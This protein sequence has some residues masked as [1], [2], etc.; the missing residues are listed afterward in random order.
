MKAIL[1][2]ICQLPIGT[3]LPT[4]LG[5]FLGFFLGSLRAGFSEKRLFLSMVNFAFV[6][7]NNNISYI[8]AHSDIIRKGEH[9]A[10]APTPAGFIKG[11]LLP[12]P[13]SLSTLTSTA[14]LARFA[15]SIIWSIVI[16]R[17][18]NARLVHA[19]LANSNYLNFNDL[20]VSFAN[21]KNMYCDL[22]WSLYCLAR[23]RNIKYSM[24]HYQALIGALNIRKP[25]TIHLENLVF[26][27]KD[28]E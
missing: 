7:L 12:F 2:W 6:D 23:N 19:Q 18:S 26:Q 15:N 27:Y 1:N 11:N 13:N 28:K 24:A 17:I 4:L 25:E 21:L 5:T 8:E 16:N 9:L 20:M 14:T 3:F 22:A 10:L